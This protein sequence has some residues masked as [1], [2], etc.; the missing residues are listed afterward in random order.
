MLNTRL[1]AA[2][3]LMMSLVDASDALAATGTSWATTPSWAS[4]ARPA[5]RRNVYN[6]GQSQSRETSPFAP[7]SHNIA[8]DL[9]QVFLMGDLVGK[10]ND[11]IGGRIHYTY[12]VSEIFGF[13]ASLGYSEHSDGK[14]SL[15]SGTAGLRVNIAWFDKVVPYFVG[16][17]GF[18]RP[19][20]ELLVEGQ[21]PTS[22]APILFGLHL[23]P[24]VTLELTKTLF[25]GTALTFHNIFGAV[26][27]TAQGPLDLGSNH[28]SF[29]LN[30][31][32][33]L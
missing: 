3:L 2:F 25:F 28:A 13:D 9:G 24:G 4:D 17:L 12:G 1:F 30:V 27:Q 20:R 23:G 5:P 11:S 29:L 32:V 6:S 19:S 8:L 15:A 33:T 22:M 18:Y 14:Y 16:G 21:S 26:R 7:G 31:G 10:Y